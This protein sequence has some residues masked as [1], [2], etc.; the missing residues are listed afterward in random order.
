MQAA[1]QK[2]RDAE[3]QV[4]LLE[5][6]SFEEAAKYH[7]TGLEGVMGDMKTMQDLQTRL[8]TLNEEAKKITAV[9]MPSAQQRTRLN[10]INSERNQIV[11][12]QVALMSKHAANLR[13]GAEKIATEQAAK[14]QAEAAQNSSAED[15]IRLPGIGDKTRSQFV[16]EYLRRHEGATE[17]EANEMFEKRAAETGGYVKKGNVENGQNQQNASADEGRNS[18]GNEADGGEN[19]TGRPGQP[20]EVQRQRLESSSQLLSR[21]GE[22]AARVEKGAT[23]TD[24]RSLD[25]LVDK[26]EELEDFVQTLYELGFDRITL[27]TDGQML[28][29]KGDRIPALFYKGELFLSLDYGEPGKYDYKSYAKHEVGHLKLEQ[30]R[31]FFGDKKSAWFVSNAVQA[32]TE[33]PEEYASLFKKYANMY[34]AYKMIDG[35]WYE[36][37]RV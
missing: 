17:A 22:E 18:L 12:Q 6:M 37:N 24:G 10:D 32:L 35:I 4:Q 19:R 7:F 21:D 29:P 23:Q 1:D 31:R 33:S 34:R 26:Y 5:N 14:A 28:D 9:H 16:Q 25:L 20:T 11:G 8:G 30:L 13:K 36:M 2:V 15:T 27:I 3:R